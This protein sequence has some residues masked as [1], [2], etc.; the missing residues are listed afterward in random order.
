MSAGGV[1]VTCA[2]VRTTLPTPYGVF[3]LNAFERPGGATL[4]ALSTGRIDDGDPVLARV[5]SE[6]LTGDALG[7]LR[8]DCGAQLRWS[9]RAITAEGR[10]VLVYATGHEGRGI[11]LINKLRAYVEQDDGADTVD[12]NLH[13]GLPVDGRDYGEAAWA[14]RA[15]GASRVRLVTNNPI[16]VRAIEAAGVSVVEVIGLPVAPHVRNSGY[17][18]TKQERMGHLN[19]IE[20]PEHVLETPPDVGRLL[21]RPRPRGD[22][23]YVVVKYAQSV[24]GRIATRTGDSK[25]ISGEDER[26]VSHALR[27]RCDAIMVGVGTVVEDDPKLTVRLVPGASPVRVVLDSG[28]RVPL[29]ARVLDDGAACVVIASHAAPRAR[30]EALRER[31]VAVRR[32]RSGGGGVDVDA[33]LAELRAMG[34]ESLLV[35]GGAHVITSLLA[36]RVVD[37]IVVSLAPVVLG[38]GVEGVGDLGVTTVAQGLTL[39]DRVLHVAGDD[40]MMAW[41]VAPSSVLG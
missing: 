28:L 40:L 30:E 27:A 38:R 32:V 33:A 10:G 5:H 13:L 37:R 14:L 18:R 23:P 15:L 9:L 29:A 3:D 22:R 6:C 12:A 4:V 11:G 20:E 24:D 39:T 35:E 7:S 1:P 16:K 17:L 31:Q 34:I 21:G 41:D 36:R 25:W 19:P 26:A 2:A 8:C